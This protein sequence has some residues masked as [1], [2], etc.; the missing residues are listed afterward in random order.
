PRPPAS[1]ERR[2]NHEDHR[3]A[4]SHRHLANLLSTILT[5]TIASICARC[6]PFRPGGR[7]TEGIWKN[8][9]RHAALTFCSTRTVR[10]G[11]NR[12][13]ENFRSSCSARE[14]WA[15]LLR[16]PCRSRNAVSC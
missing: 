13:A 7:K 4:H 14:G 15:P 16:H 12:R 8:F 2:E 5:G 11:Q 6:S 1:A 9:A 3:F 10:E